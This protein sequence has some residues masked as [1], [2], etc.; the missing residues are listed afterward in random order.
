MRSRVSLSVALVLAVAAVYP[1]VARRREAGRVAE[2]VQAV[3]A[4]GPGEAAPAGVVVC[5]GASLAVDPALLVR[6]D[7]LDGLLASWQTIGGC[8]AGAGAA[9]SAGIKWV[10]RNVSGGLFNVQEQ[11]SYSNIGSGQYAEHN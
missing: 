2:R 9:S 8:G 3:V 5:D 1:T 6:V 11:V 10:G 7:E 4:N